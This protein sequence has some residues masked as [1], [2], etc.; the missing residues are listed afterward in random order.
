MQCRRASI[1]KSDT[2]CKVPLLSTTANCCASKPATH[3]GVI[4]LSLKAFDAFAALAV[5]VTAGRLYSL[6]TA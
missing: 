5:L 4:A 3:Q 6:D 2:K 1:Q